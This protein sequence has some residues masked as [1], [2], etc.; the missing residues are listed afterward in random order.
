MCLLI[1]LYKKKLLNYMSK[2]GTLK[3][4]KKFN[5]FKMNYVK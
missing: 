4:V 2:Y 3:K 1:N 5:T